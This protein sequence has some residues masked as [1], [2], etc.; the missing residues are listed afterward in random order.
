MCSN[1]YNKNRKSEKSKLSYFF[2]KTIFLLFTV[3]AV[4]NMKKYL[5]KQNQLKNLINNKEECQKTYSHIWTKYKSRT[6]TKKA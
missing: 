2:K 5:K 4:M 6:E 1:V 3:S